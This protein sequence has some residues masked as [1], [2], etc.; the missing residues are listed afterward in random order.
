MAMKEEVTFHVDTEMHTGM[1]RISALVPDLVLNMYGPKVLEAVMLDITSRIV[2]HW[3][4]THSG[5]VME[6]LAPGLIAETIK[7]KLAAEMA[8]KVLG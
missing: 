6:M 4:D 5:E 3:W 1:R 8:K 2:Q 7:A